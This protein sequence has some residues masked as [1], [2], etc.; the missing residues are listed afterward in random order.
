MRDYK[1]SKIKNKRVRRGRTKKLSKKELLIKGKT[2]FYG[3]IF[4]SSAFLVAFIIWKFAPH[5]LLDQKFL[6]VRNVKI[7]GN[8]NVSGK[9]IIGLSEVEGK[10]FLKIKLPE[11]AQKIAKNPWIKKVDLRRKLPKGICITV[12]ERTP[13]AYVQLNN[14]INLV[15]EEGVIIR[16]V[17]ETEKKELPVMTGFKKKVSLKPGD[18]IPFPNLKT[19]IEILKEIQGNGL[20][21][22]SNISTLDV[23]NDSNPIL[24]LKD[25]PGQIY[26]GLGEI[27]EKIRKLKALYE[28]TRNQTL[29][30]VSYID[31]R[32]R[33]RVIVMPLGKGDQ[34]KGDSL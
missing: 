27:G 10:N 23:R 3:I 24:T 14:L 6:T 16:I 22:V 17:S 28:N 21:P 12:E 11:T 8:K 18:R 4:L 32:F 20:I 25:L 30:P 19:G 2:V 29:P 7:I 1:R 31:L 5:T 33:D 26:L 9:E 15:D 34:D 13:F